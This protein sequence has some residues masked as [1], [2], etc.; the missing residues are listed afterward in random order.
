MIEEISIIVTCDYCFKKFE[1]EYMKFQCQECV[2]NEEYTSEH[3]QN[4]LKEISEEKHQWEDREHYIGFKSEEDKTLYL[5]GVYRGYQVALFGVA[6]WF[7]EVEFYEKL[8]I[9]S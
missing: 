5:K 7:G 4:C 8:P 6:D 1:L 3:I 2:P 9:W